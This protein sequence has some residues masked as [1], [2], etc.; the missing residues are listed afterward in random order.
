MGR[1][2]GYYDRFLGSEAAGAYRVGVAFGCQVTEA[3]SVEAHDVRMG[4]LVV[5]GEWV[6]V[7]GG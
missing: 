2:R 7:L 6:E 5:A 3:V 4:A 1:G